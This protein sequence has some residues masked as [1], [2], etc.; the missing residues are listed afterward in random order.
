[1]RLSYARSKIANG[2]GVTWDLLCKTLLVCNVADIDHSSAL[3]ALLSQYGMK[4][5]AELQ[6][7]LLTFRHTPAEYA[8]DFE[9]ILHT[10]RCKV[11]VSIHVSLS[12]SY[13]IF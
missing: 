1:M 12:L 5:A 8:D 13:D 11:R 4:G 9:Y 6:C 2:N 10:N 3:S 7:Q